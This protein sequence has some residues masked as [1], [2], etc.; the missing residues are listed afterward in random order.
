LDLLLSILCA[1]AVACYEQRIFVRNVHACFV[2]KGVPV[3]LQDRSDAAFGGQKVERG[4]L[5][6]ETHGG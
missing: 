4:V 2:G 6:L 5:C 1:K 3:V